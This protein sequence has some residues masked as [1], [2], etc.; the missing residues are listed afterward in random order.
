MG[1]LGKIGKIEKMGKMGDLGR[2]GKM[3]KLG[4][5]GALAVIP[6]EILY[7]CTV[8]TSV[9]KNPP[10]GGWCFRTW[11]LLTIPTKVFRSTI[12]RDEVHLLYAIR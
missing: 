2:L 12:L 7:I 3:G 4:K 11:W 10:F 5:I 8:L 6:V 9:Q 1:G